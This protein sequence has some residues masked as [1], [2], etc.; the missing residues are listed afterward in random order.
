M[1]TYACKFG[2]SCKFDHPQSA[3]PK[4]ALPVPGNLPIRKMG[5]TMPSTGIPY[6]G[7]LPAWSLPS[8]SYVATS[9]VSGPHTYLPVVFPSLQT[10]LT[11]Q[12][13]NGYM[14]SEFSI[15]LMS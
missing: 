8:S 2:P 4:T 15:F 12:C 1:R 6:V 14:V 7:T 9:H 5:S 3:L 10:P 11:A 13:W